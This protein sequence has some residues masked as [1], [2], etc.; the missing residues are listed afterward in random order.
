M[1]DST[2]TLGGTVKLDPLTTVTSF[3]FPA[4]GD[5]IVGEVRW[6]GTSVF[7]ARDFTAWAFGD[8]PDAYEGSQV[9]MYFPT[10]A[11]VTTTAVYAKTNTPGGTAWPFIRSPAIQCYSV[12]E[13]PTPSGYCEMRWGGN[14]TPFE[15]SREQWD[16]VEVI[17]G[18]DVIFTFTPAG[19][20]GTVDAGSNRY[21]QQK[22]PGAP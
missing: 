7:R 11:T 17:S 18:G 6:A 9:K 12:D 2:V 1:V 14:P 20:C 16:K 8:A 5:W 21:Y 13:I 10:L 15:T 4:S 22:G 3:D 19:A